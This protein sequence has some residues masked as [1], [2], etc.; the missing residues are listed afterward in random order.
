MRITRIDFLAIPISGSVLPRCIIRK[1][2]DGWFLGSH[3]DSEQMIDNFDLDQALAWCTAHG[4]AVHRWSQ[5]ARAWL[6]EV[7]P[8]RDS[9]G[10]RARRK[11]LEREAHG[12]TGHESNIPDYTHWGVYGHDLAFD[13]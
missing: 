7:R 8:V 13:W 11:S 12:F 1:Y 4:W 5:G 10:I 6:G 9:Q 2:A 3:S